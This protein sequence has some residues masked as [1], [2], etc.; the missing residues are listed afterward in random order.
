MCGALNIERIWS[1]ETEQANIIVPYMSLNKERIVS[2]ETEQV[3]YTIILLTSVGVHELH[4]L[5]SQFGLAF[6]YPRTTSKNYR[7]G[8]VARALLI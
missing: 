7:Q 6:L 5:A 2:P 3:I 8:R 1:L 4:E